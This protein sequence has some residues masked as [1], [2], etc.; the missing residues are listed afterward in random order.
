MVN[1]RILRLLCGLMLCFQAAQAQQWVEQMND[2]SV[3][4]YTLQQEFNN[5]WQGRTVERG[6]GWKQFKRYESFMAPRVY[7]SGDRSLPS[8]SWKEYE[9][10]VAASPAARLSTT[11]SNWTSM[12][13]FS[14]PTNGGGAGRIGF[15]RF[16][17]TTTSTMWVGSPGGGLWKST[18]SGSTWSTNT[19]NLSVIG[20]SD[21]LIDPTNTNIMYLA[22]G[23]GDA[24]DTRSVGVLK[25]T[26]GG[27]TWA[28]TGLAWGVS[29]NYRI[30][31]MLMHP[32]DPNTIFVATNGGVYRSTNAAANWSQVS[33][34]AAYDIEFK[35]GDPTIMYAAGIGFYRSTNSGASFTQVTSGVPTSNNRLAIGVT[36]ANTGYVYLLAGKSSDSGFNGLYRSTDSG[37]SFATRST[38][39]NIL[40]WQPTGSDAGGQSWYDLSIAVSPTNAEEVITGG[41]NVWRSTNGGSTWTINGHWTGSGAPYVHADIHALEFLPGSSSTYFAGCDGGIFKTTNNGTAWTDISSNLSIAQLYKLGMSATNANLVVSGWQDNGTNRWNGTSWSRIYGG[42]GMECFID[43][44]NNSY[45]YAELYYG[46]FKRSADGGSTWTAIKPSGTTDGDW[47]T[48]WV[49]DPNN[50]QTLYA[51]F[52]QIWKSTN[53]GTSW[54]QLGSITGT[55]NFTSLAVAPSN[56]SVIYAGRPTQLWKTSDGGSTWTNISTGLPTSSAS[57]TYVTVH[58]TDP[59]RLWVTFSGY[60]SANKVFT[61]TNGGSTWTNLSTGLPNLPVNCVV[62]EKDSPDRIYVG[63]DIGVYLRDNTVAGWQAYFTGLPNVIVQELEIYYPT[64]KIRAATYGRGLWQSDLPTTN[65]V[66]ADFT[67][68]KQESLHRPGRNL[69]RPVYRFAYQ[70]ELELSGRHACQLYGPEPYCYLQHGRYLQR[71]PDGHEWRFGQYSYQNR[72]HYGKGCG[73]NTVY[74][75]L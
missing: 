14:V 19:D 11:G 72:L 55:T 46:Q 57:I 6:K 27:T 31:K 38:S 66:A 9:Q 10:F 34:V 49:M 70:L 23:D 50:P 52:A 56:S 40:G 61:S 16:H 35:P 17:P 18:N 4:F 13:P 54:V 64:R 33:S 20:V 12:G 67:S 59:N 75:S 30:R 47:V 29:Q 44:S 8:R 3:N 73:G 48:P 68:N 62:F 15:V 45:M 28:A 42:D 71:D 2:P 60:S 26:D 51:G 43:P 53:R 21:V 41:V 22:T 36:N 5:Y 69:H 25:S 63:T 1:S 32:S 39:P 24:G 58:P 7:P 74:R 37:L 65:S